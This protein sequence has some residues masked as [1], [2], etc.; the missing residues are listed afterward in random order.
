[1]KKVMIFFIFLILSINLISA[2]SY[3][4]IPTCEIKG[5]IKKV[6]F[7]EAHNIECEGPL[8]CPTNVPKNY[9]DRYKLEIIVKE[10]SYIYGDISYTSCEERYPLNSEHIIYILKESIN[11]GDTLKEG[12]AIQGYVEHSW[13]NYFVSYSLI[14]DNL[15]YY[16]II[17]TL[18]L[19]IIVILTIVLILKKKQ[20]INSQN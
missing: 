8:E 17:G 2:A 19:L 4:P 1:M 12:K 10:T 14:K 9:P 3:A 13:E 15:I 7:E 6:Q 16:Y 11:E 18:I 20:H 5:N